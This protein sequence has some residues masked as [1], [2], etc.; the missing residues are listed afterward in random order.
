MT[1]FVDQAGR[2]SAAD[3]KFPLVDNARADGRFNY[4]DSFYEGRSTSIRKRGPR[5]ILFVSCT[6]TTLDIPF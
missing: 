4:R 5:L 1:D 6:G 3:A 2:S